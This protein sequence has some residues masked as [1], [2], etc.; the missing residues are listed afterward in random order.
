[1]S[2]TIVGASYKEATWQG[3]TGGSSRLMI[4]EQENFRDEPSLAELKRVADPANA[5]PANRPGWYKYQPGMNPGSDANVRTNFITNEVLSGNL[6][7]KPGRAGR[8]NILG[9]LNIPLLWSIA[10]LIRN[11]LQSR[12]TADGSIVVSTPHGA[13]TPLVVAATTT[14]ADGTKTVAN[15]LS[16]HTAAPAQLKI[17]LVQDIADVNSGSYGIITITGKDHW[18]NV[19]SDTYFIEPVTAND[20]AVSLNSEYFWKEITSVVTSGFASGST[21]T[22]SI[23]A[24]DDA[25]QMMF[26]PYDLLMSSYLLMDYNVGKIPNFF[27]GAYAASAVLEVTGQ[28]ALAELRVG[29]G[30]RQGFQSERP[31]E[32]YV[33]HKT[34]GAVIYASETG[35]A[36]A[37]ADTTNYTL[38]PQKVPEFDAAWTDERKA[39]FWNTDYR[40]RKPADVEII[41]DPVMDT[42]RAEI[43]IAG[44]PIPIT[45]VTYDFGLNF[46]P[47]PVITDPD[48]N[49]PPT[50][51]S[52]LP[53]LSGTYQTSLSDRLGG[54]ALSGVK[55]TYLDLVFNEKGLGAFPGYHKARCAKTQIQERSIASPVDGPA[56]SQFSMLGLPSQG[57]VS[58]DI[59]YT[60]YAP[61]GQVVRN[62]A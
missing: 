24:R 11:I 21:G 14:L 29:L 7:A 58:D 12:S 57:G 59:I 43:I 44:I 52:R 26:K 13:I 4:Y 55:A 27:R 62:Y 23:T 33:V 50:R 15:N 2:N 1:M 41:T 56:L 22:F 31:T 35:Y 5:T 53:T 6:T 61:Y 45:T 47:S 38:V 16:T 40:L 18:D 20:T 9:T 28:D 48:D 49:T 8:Q 51:Q 54:A 46:E 36:T 60:I 3:E 39:E 30:G 32:D 10:P 25:V 42:N 34:T 17:D 37:L 19:L